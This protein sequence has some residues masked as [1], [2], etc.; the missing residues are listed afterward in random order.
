VSV[1][2]TKI[3]SGI[4]IFSVASVMFVSSVS[5]GF[6]LA[7]S[8]GPASVS[9][10]CFEASAPTASVDTSEVSTVFFGVMLE[11]LIVYKTSN[12]LIILFLFGVTV[13]PFWLFSVSIFAEGLKTSDVFA[14][15]VLG[16]SIF[17]IAGT[18]ASPLIS[19]SRFLGS[20]NFSVARTSTNSLISGNRV[21]SL[22]S[23]AE[24]VSPVYSGT[25]AGSI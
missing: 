20:S 23:V 8:E 9:N 5:K 18:S 7:A 11:D 25:M 13:G 14:F 3:G 12:T 1:S 17:S 4:F 2:S 22:A 24:E 19:G 6:T 16:S 10:C 21:G 15:S